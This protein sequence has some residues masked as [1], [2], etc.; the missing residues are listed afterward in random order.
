LPVTTTRQVSNE[1]FYV[2]FMDW[3]RKI[4][5]LASVA[6]ALL[7]LYVLYGL[8]F[9]GGSQWTTLDAAARTRITGNIQGA[10]TYFNV[11]MAV[12]LICL[13]I[14]YFDEEVLGY[15]LVIVS[16]ALI[17][18]SPLLL[19]FLSAGMIQAWAQPPENLPAIAAF[20]E[21]RIIGMFAGVPGGLLVLR[22]ISLRLVG[23]VRKSRDRMANMEYGGQI[24]EEKPP[25]TPILGVMAKCWQM[26]FCRAAI[27]K[28][29]PIYHARTRCWRERVGC[30]CEEKVVRTAL[31]GLINFDSSFKDPLPPAEK[32]AESRIEG[33]SIG[34]GETRP[35]DQPVL[36]VPEKTQEVPRRVRKAPPPKPRDV[37]I[38]H[39]PNIPMA[40]KIERCR[41]CVIYNEH[42]RYKYK[43]FA[44]IVVL[45]VPGLAYLYFDQLMEGLRQALMRADVVFRHLSLD[46]KAAATGVADLANSS[47]MFAQYLIF[48]C[49]LII[50]L[51]FTLR[52]LEYLVFKLKV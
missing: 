23:G 49:S 14:G 17:F 6:A 13:I 32:P 2:L 29:C 48:I 18:G 43:F 22:D 7:A 10:I 26:N 8:I 1:R 19:E 38:P 47:N 20:N 50:V 16:V 24:K 12:V 25:S 31:E 28:D 41:N 46:S 21:L 3:V 36:A 15:T 52:L 45:G 33:F 40:A 5:Q 34:G 4:L 9:G 44:P 27:R 37:R 51:T 39:N 11:A 35:E 42:Q 30:M